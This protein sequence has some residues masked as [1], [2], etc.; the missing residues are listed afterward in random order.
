MATAGLSLLGFMTQKEAIA[1]LSAHCVP[2][3]PDIQA[4]IGEWRAAQA[5]KGAPM[6][7][8]NSNILDIPAANRP[9]I[10]MLMQQQW[11]TQFLALQPGAE[12]KLV[13]IDPLLTIH[14]MVDLE[15][16]RR[17]CAG[18]P[19]D[20]SVADL[21]P[22][23]LPATFGNEEIN[24]IRLPDGL[25]KQ[26]SAGSLLMT[27][28]SLNVR[29][30]DAGY[31]QADNKIG[32]QFGMPMPLVHVVRYNGRCY[33]HDGLHRTIGVRQK[34]ATHVPCLFRDASSAADIGL[35]PDRSTFS[36]QILESADAP[37][38][39]HFTQG[40]AYEVQLKRYRRIVHV[41]WAEYSIADE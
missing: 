16:S 33:L 37:T 27:A 19:H 10:E 22:V 38:V 35:K 25:G 9:Y 39:G 29:V 6:A 15:R 36:L 4:L 12:F 40:R 32:I 18:V 41:T 34:G 17:R 7:A 28:R 2:A 21:L 31:F 3:S 26:L 30:V 5:R 24:I 13:E 1:H 14:F 8:G 20:P 11:V 23:C